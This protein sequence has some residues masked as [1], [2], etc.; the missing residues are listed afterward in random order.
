M[1]HIGDN[2]SNKLVQM[3]S[4]VDYL[5]CM[6]EVALGIYQSPVKIS[7]PS[8]A[9]IYYLCKQTEDYLPFF[10]Q[11]SN[12]S[13]FVEGEIRSRNL[14]ESRSNYE[15]DGYFI[16]KSDKKINI[17]T[18]LFTILFLV[19]IGMP[20]VIILGSMI[21]VFSPVR[22][23]YWITMVFICILMPTIM[24]LSN[25]FNIYLLK[26]YL[27]ENEEIQKLN[28]KAIFVKDLLNPLFFILGFI[29][30]AVITFLAM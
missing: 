7:E 15:R 23:M 6:I 24:A 14:K 1:R 9:G 2:I 12:Q 22:V 18:T 3:S 20:F 29:V 19:I 28:M 16:Y 17:K 10:E 21:T 4:G 30:C 25:T 26:N 27:E 11:A 13:W 5:C 8:F